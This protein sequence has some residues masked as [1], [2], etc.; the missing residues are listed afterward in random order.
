MRLKSFLKAI[1]PEVYVSVD[2][3][4]GRNLAFNQAESIIKNND[5][6]L[7]VVGAYPESF[8]GLNGRLGIVVLVVD[9]ERE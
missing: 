9:I 2:H 3:A 5:Q 7:D 8:A 6:R 1:D 4:D